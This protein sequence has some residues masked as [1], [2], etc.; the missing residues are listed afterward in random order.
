MLIDI[1]ALHVRPQSILVK[2]RNQL[3]TISLM[4]Q[5][6][7]GEHANSVRRV[8]EAPRPEGEALGPAVPGPSGLRPLLPMLPFGPPP[9]AAELN[10]HDMRAAV[11][12]LARDMAWRSSCSRFLELVMLRVPW[13][14]RRVALE[15][16]YDALPPLSRPRAEVQGA[17]RLPEMDSD[18]DEDWGGGD[19]DSPQS[20]DVSEAGSDFGP[21]GSEEDPEYPPSSQPAPEV[22]VVDSDGDEGV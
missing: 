2:L 4:D 10:H 6:R 5:G 21:S 11:V 13:C 7:S 19:M 14:P 3:R 15:A 1:P 9:L 22:I 8:R 12:R 20:P 17:V 16:Y 18:E